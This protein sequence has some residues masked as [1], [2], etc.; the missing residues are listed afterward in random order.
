LEAAS[1]SN[2]HID[3]STRR[4]NL[5]TGVPFERVVVCKRCGLQGGDLIHDEQ[6]PVA[7]LIPISSASGVE[8]QERRLASALLAVMYAVPEFARALLKPLGAPA[9]RVEAFIEVPFK[10]EGRAIRPDG[11]LTVARAGKSWTALVETKTAGNPLLS[12]QINT[13][14]PRPSSGTRI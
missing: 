14:L 3:R 11:L 7:R 5:P 4:W 10:L 6:W 9:G 1:G 12:E 13:Y 8:A 2:G